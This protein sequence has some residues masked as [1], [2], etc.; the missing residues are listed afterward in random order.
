[1][2]LEFT[3][4]RILKFKSGNLRFDNTGEAFEVADVLASSLLKEITIL[5]GE[6]TPIFREVSE[7]PPEEKPKRK[8]KRKGALVAEAEN[9]GIETTP[10]NQ[11]IEEIEKEIKENADR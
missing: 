10:D 11:T 8:R 3:D 7:P 4:K 2:I 6:K 1:M 9:L 5:G